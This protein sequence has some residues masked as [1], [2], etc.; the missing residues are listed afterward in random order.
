MEIETQKKDEIK[1]THHSNPELIDEFFDSENTSFSR[2]YTDS[3][4][5]VFSDQQKLDKFIIRIEKGNINFSSSNF[6]IIK[7]DGDTILH[8]KFKTH[9]L[10][11]GY[12]LYEIK[13]DAELIQHIKSRVRSNLGEK[14]FMNLS[15]KHEMIEYR[16][17]SEFESFE[18]FLECEALGLP[19]YSFH[20][21]EEDGTYFGYSK[22]NKKIQVVFG[23]C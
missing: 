16:E 9:E 21:G 13:T 12:A 18:T 1:P 17:I 15:E 11:N 22:I 7:F 5:H 8:K 10:I 14:A 20:L 2:N 19:L 23:C 3:S 6:T 4:L